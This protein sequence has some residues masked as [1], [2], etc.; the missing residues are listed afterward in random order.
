MTTQ[1]WHAGV[2]LQIMQNLQKLHWSTSQSSLNNLKAGFTDLWVIV[3]PSFVFF[4]QSFHWVNVVCSGSRHFE[5]ER[6]WGWGLRYIISAV[7]LHQKDA[8]SYMTCTANKMAASPLSL[9]CARSL[10]IFPYQKLRCFCTQGDSH[11]VHVPVML[12]ECLSF[13]APR[14]GQVSDESCHRFRFAR[15]NLSRQNET[16][17]FLLLNSVLKVLKATVAQINHF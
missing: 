11:T 5:S 14:D 13:L 17:F 3:L 4:L 12:K 7:G 10:F 16:V 1:E 8:A 9:Y 6:A 2:A 15:G